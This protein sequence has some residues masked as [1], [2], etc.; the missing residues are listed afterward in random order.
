MEQENLLI[1]HRLTWWLGSQGGL[2]A[3]AAFIF[4]KLEALGA[5]GSL[6]SAQAFFQAV[7]FAAGI[8]GTLTSIFFGRAIH[9]A[10]AAH[11][12]LEIWWNAHYEDPK[13]T[14]L[15]LTKH[16]PICGDEP[17]FPKLHIGYHHLPYTFICIWIFVV[18]AS[19]SRAI[20]EHTR[21][22]LWLSE[23]AMTLILLGFIFYMG[24]VTVYRV[25]SGLN[26]TRERALAAY[27]KSKGIPE[28][29]SRELL[30]KLSDE[31]ELKKVSKAAQQ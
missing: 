4:P 30:E 11:R 24:K 13:T 2:I 8:V 26:K 31:K 19:I 23:A 10:H 1:N 27:L 18:L 17:L 25:N 15:K 14:P 9:A 6:Q 21:Y 16:P 5:Q 20:L 22:V 29:E 12:R 28:E 7:L 3:V